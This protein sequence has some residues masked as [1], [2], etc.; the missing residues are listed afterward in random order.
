MDDGNGGERAWVKTLVPW[1][2]TALAAASEPD[3]TV[4][5]SAGYELAYTSEV[6]RYDWDDTPEGCA[7]KYQTDLLISDVCVDRKWWIPRV[8]VECKLGGVST[9]SAQTY[10]TKAGTHKQVHPYL[11][12]GFLMAEVGDHIPAR[13]IR[14]GVHFDFIAAVQNKKLNR[15]ERGLL[16][17]VLLDE[18]RASRKLHGLFLDRKRSRERCR[19][20]HRGLTVH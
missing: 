16:T 13:V 12:Y 4:D 5:V 15:A 2:G 19:F 1:L 6:L 18:V 10:S 20:L 8:V 9:H 17:E 3:R 7:N 11:R 14:H